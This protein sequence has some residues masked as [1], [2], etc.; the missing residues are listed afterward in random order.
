[1]SESRDQSFY[2]LL[3]QVICPLPLGCHFPRTQEKPH[4]ST[5]EVPSTG[6]PS[7]PHSHGLHGLPPQ[8]TLPTMARDA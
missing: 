7:H 4:E 3:A 2:H 1:M 8:H 5:V 6:R